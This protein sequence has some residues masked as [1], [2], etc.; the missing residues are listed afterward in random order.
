MSKEPKKKKRRLK[1]S[2]IFGCITFIVFMV[3]IYCVYDIY[4]NMKDDKEKVVEVI[5]SI[6]GYDYSLDENDS[7]YVQDLFKKLKETLEKEELDEEEY[8]KVVSQIFI[9][10][11]YSL[12]ASISKN[13]IGGVQFVYSD[14]QK[15]FVS[16]AKSS[17]YRSVENNL[18]KN[19]KQELP[20]VSKVTVDDIKQTTATY[21]MESTS[22][23]DA[24]VLPL[25][26]DKAYVV[27][28]TIEYEEELGYPDEVTLVLIHSNDKLEVSEME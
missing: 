28:V 13:D 19:R 10:D 9:A 1:L 14:Y 18:N 3:M 27:K 23:E 25:E 5:D 11:F 7:K 8:A 26:D 4:N 16:L 6:K 2:V 24:E 20:I 21:D 12:D 22:D 15:D 17:I